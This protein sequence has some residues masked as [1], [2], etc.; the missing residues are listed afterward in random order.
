MTLP[1]RISGSLALCGLLCSIAVA[2]QAPLSEDQ[3]LL[4][5]PQG[6]NIRNVHV[7]SNTARIS[8]AKKIT[9]R[10]G[11][12][13]FEIEELRFE[14]VDDADQAG[15]ANLPVE[16][17]SP[18]LEARP[19]D[20]RITRASN[21]RRYFPRGTEIGRVRAE[22]SRGGKRVLAV[23]RQTDLAAA[24][25]VT[26]WIADERSTTARTK[27]VEKLVSAAL[28]RD[29]GRVYVQ[30]SDGLYVCESSA[31]GP[32]CELLKIS[33]L[34]EPHTLFELTSRR[35]RLKPAYF[36]LVR[37]LGIDFYPSET[38]LGPDGTYPPLTPL[39]TLETSNYAIAT[40]FDS[41]TRLMLVL[42][43]NRVRALRVGDDGGELVAEMWLEP[44]SEFR[45]CSSLHIES[46]DDP[47]GSVVWAL[48]MRRNVEKPSRDREGS[49]EFAALV[50]GLSKNPEQT[51]FE[52]LAEP[53][54]KSC[55]RWG[56]YSP[57]I[58]FSRE[59][60]EVI[61]Y[62]RDKAWKVGVAR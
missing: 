1:K 39:A 17:A 20:Q 2:Y 45:S 23:S 46:D 60:S 13:A 50:V 28:S 58:Q 59:S 55:E 51:S 42:E 5:L 48:G 26:V 36:F 44:G 47:K 54:W 9:N 41:E 15:L 57:R 19:V 7:N 32:R 56:G 29:G 38:E 6:E 61:A 31:F 43:H 3:F 34:G 49:A 62:T 53:T 52:V 22:L 12:P 27:Q 30:R 10:E 37:K 33:T 18:S 40:L 16:A 4:E 24:A 8:I 14:L 25:D 11:E 21:D 35:G